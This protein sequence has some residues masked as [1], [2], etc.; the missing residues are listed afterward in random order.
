MR[1]ARSS[2]RCPTRTSLGCRR[3]AELF[4]DYV[5]AVGWAQ[6]YAPRT[7]RNDAT[8]LIER[9]REPLGRPLGTHG[10]AINC[11]HNYVAR[12]HHSARTCCVTRKG[13]VRASAGELGIIPGSMGAR[14]Y[15]VRGKGNPESLRLLLARRRAAHVARRG[16]APLHAR[17]PRGGRP[18]GVECR[19]DA[20][21][22]DE[23]PGAYKDIDAVMA[24]QPTS[25]RSSHT[26]K[27]IVCVKG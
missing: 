13:A 17:R 1:S 15:I 4:A 16:E 25:S 8:R 5:A 22:I 23:I 26:L 9:A 10:R 21:V 6:D 24:A 14:S 11:H 19:K 12:E 20:G 3:V 18:A 7:A 2:R 27:Q